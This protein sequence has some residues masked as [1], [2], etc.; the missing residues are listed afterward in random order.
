MHCW[1]CG[2]PRAKPLSGIIPFRRAGAGAMSCQCITFASRP[3]SPISPIPSC[4]AMRWMLMP[5]WRILMYEKLPIGRQKKDP[6]FYRDDR[7][8]AAL[9]SR[10]LRS[11]TISRSPNS[12][13]SMQEQE[14]QVLSAFSSRRLIRRSRTAASFRPFADCVLSGESLVALVFLV[15]L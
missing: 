8:K 14:R 5:C 4:S 6:D 13:T 15:L 11:G 2:R 3:L 7:Q 1:L 9:I 12:S 10:R